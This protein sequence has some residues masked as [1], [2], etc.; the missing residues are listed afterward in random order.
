[1][2]TTIQPDAFL[3]QKRGDAVVYELPWPIWD[4]ELKGTRTSKT[5]VHAL[6]GAACGITLLE[7]LRATKVSR[8]LVR[9]GS[10]PGLSEITRTVVTTA[11]PIEK[12]VR[13]F[14]VLVE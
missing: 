7:D 6:N 9:A 5:T 12:R 8:V 4:G 13:S 14:R 11:E 10:M 3:T 1:M 2:A